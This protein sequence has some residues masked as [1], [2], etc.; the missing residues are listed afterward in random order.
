MTVVDA[1]KQMN[2]RIITD[3]DVVEQLV[4]GGISLSSI[5]T[6][7]FSHQHMDHIG[8]TSLFPASTKLIVG[9]G[10]I[11]AHT[12][13]Y[14]T[15]ASSPIP[16]SALVGRELQELEF[17]DFQI[18]GF[19][20]KDY[21]GDGSLY[22]LSTPG[23]TV[24]HVS[25]LARVQSNS[26][27]FLGGDVCHHAGELRPTNKVPLCNKLYQA[28]HPQ[29]RHD[30]PFY[31]TAFSPFNHDTEEARRSVNMVTEFDADPNIMILLAHDNSLLE[32]IDLFPKS[33]N[34]W[35]DKGWKERN[36]WQFLSDLDVSQV[37]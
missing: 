33:I 16:D 4:A 28:V 22:F 23:H 25:A 8:D 10:F 27:V 14:P 17:S 29:Q 30:S 31:K 3:E 37:N 19:Q 35:K 2:V 7:C 6:I 26:F 32:T 15:N 20:A 9:P 5:D 21:F 24:G 18:G 36:T 12:P 13:G 11:E 34:D 1:I